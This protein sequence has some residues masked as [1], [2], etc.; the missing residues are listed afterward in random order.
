MIIERDQLTAEFVLARI[1]DL[2]VDAGIRINELQRKHAATTLLHTYSQDEHLFPNPE[3]LNLSIVEIVLMETPSKTL[4]LYFGLD[5]IGLPD[6]D[7][8]REMRR[9]FYYKDLDAHGYGLLVN[10]ASLP[11]SV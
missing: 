6:T 8:I 4:R 9:R 1:D 3:T 7:I 11:K 5:C 2:S 10:I